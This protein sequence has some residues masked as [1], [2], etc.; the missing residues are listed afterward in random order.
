VLVEIAQ[1]AD[2]QT[3]K[4]LVK[5]LRLQCNSLED[6]AIQLL[7][8]RGLFTVAGRWM[9]GKKSNE[10][11]ALRW[12]I[13]RDDSVDVIE[14]ARLLERLIGRCGEPEIAEE[15]RRFL[16]ECNDELLRISAENLSTASTELGL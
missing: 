16:I 9:Q 5:E 15:N 14:R 8:E 10:I 7:L 13:I 4:L 3:M 1:H 2:G 6:T 11:D 12:N